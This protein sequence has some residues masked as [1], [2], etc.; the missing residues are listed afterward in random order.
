MDLSSILSAGAELIKNN[1]DDATTNLDSSSI[2]SALGGLL[3]GG[4]GGGLDI[5]SL[6]SNLS[7]GDLGS[8][9]QSWVGNGE[10]LPI[11]ADAISD[12]L[13]SDKIAAFASQLG[14]SEDSAKTALA[15]ALPNIVDQATDGS[16]S[17]MVEGLLAQVGGVGGAMG[18]LG[19]MFKS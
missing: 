1:S 7:S 4:S 2:T 12:L 13:G 11:S 15:D 9:I 16:E 17:S 6:L 14:L 19:K 3:G 5:G 10:N 18:M 8:T